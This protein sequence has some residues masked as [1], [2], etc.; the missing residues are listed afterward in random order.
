MYLMYI[1][2][3][4]DTATP[5]Q[6]GSAFLVL[7]GCIIHE[8]DKLAIET[9]FRDIKKAYYFD[10][11]VEIKSNFLRYANPDIPDMSSPIKLHDR[12]KYDALEADIAQF[13]KDIN[14]T[15]ISIVIHKAAYWEKYPAQN[16][17]DAAYIF[18][19]ERFQTFLKFKGEQETF[20]LCIIDPREGR[21]EKQFI[22]A[23]LNK[24]HHLL[25]WEEGG[26]WKRCPNVIEKLLFSPS[27]TTV[28][29][30]IADLYAY[31]VFHIFEYNKKKEDYW[32]FAEVTYPKLYFH[33]SV[34][35]SADPAEIGPVIDGT[36]L[37]FFPDKTKKDF[38]FFQI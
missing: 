19:V 35:A 18:L 37:K 26:F 6:G 14:A 38:R 4:G 28:G 11:D 25:R 36:G 23:E 31:P 29:I 22:G 5:Q 2:E 24:T 10:P 1:D 30:Q 13:L 9:R 15:V 8:N 7:A 12:K 20:G 21:V 33:Q 17:Y 3:A 34:T 32:R 16:P 27:D